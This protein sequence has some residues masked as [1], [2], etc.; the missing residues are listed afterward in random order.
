[1][2]TQ[3]IET[4]TK[5][6]VQ[7][8][9]EENEWIMLNA[10]AGSGKTYFSAQLAVERARQ[11]LLT[12]FVAADKNGMDNFKKLVLN[13]ID[14][15]EQ[16]DLD[17]IQEITAAHG[18]TTIFRPTRIVITHHTYFSFKPMTHHG[19]DVLDECLD[20]PSNLIIIDEAHR[21]FEKMLIRVQIGEYYNCTNKIKRYNAAGTMYQSWNSK[22]YNKVH[23][24]RTDM[25]HLPILEHISNFIENPPESHFEIDITK[26]DKYEVDEIDLKS[27]DWCNYKLLKPPKDTEPDL[28]YPEKIQEL[29][30]KELEEYILN[31]IYNMPYFLEDVRLVEKSFKSRQKIYFKLSE[32]CL[33]LEQQRKIFQE[34]GK[35]ITNIEIQLTDIKGKLYDLEQLHFPSYTLAP[36]IFGLETRAIRKIRESGVTTMVMSATFDSTAR[37]LFDRLSDTEDSIT[38]LQT[39]PKFHETRVNILTHP[40]DIKWTNKLHHYEVEYDSTGYLDTVPSPKLFHIIE[41]LLPMKTLMFTTNKN[42]CEQIID[43]ESKRSNIHHGRNQFQAQTSDLSRREQ[44]DVS[45]IMSSVSF[46]SNRFTNHEVVFCPIRA[47]K[48]VNI[49]F[50][51]TVSQIED[52]I[53]CDAVNVAKQ[54]ISRIIRNDPNAK[55]IEKYIVLYNCEVFSPLDEIT[56]RIGR[57][58]THYISCICKNVNNMGVFHKI[59]NDDEYYQT[60]T[61]MDIV[62][63]ISGKKIFTYNEEVIGSRGR[64]TKNWL[65]HYVSLMK[66]MKAS[67]KSIAAINRKLNF[68]RLKKDSA[69]YDLYMDAL[70]QLF[71]EKELEKF[72]NNNHTFPAE[73]L[74]ITV[75]AKEI[76]IFENETIKDIPTKMENIV[77]NIADDFEFDLDD[78]KIL[79]EEDHNYQPIGVDVDSIDFFSDVGE[80]L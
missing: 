36:E 23:S 47:I 54:N 33:E 64:P 63:T 32:K 3:E 46:G 50:G 18:V 1:M 73:P 20:D 70:K 29:E 76:E 43:L 79:T 31:Y 65:E 48:P 40:S 78:K 37:L 52:N 25:Y 6:F 42:K 77:D 41:T 17:L 62:N 11:D 9:V 55:K 21:W 58:V 39:E 68:S 2:K 5:E 66:P 80:I 22:Y 51:N 45:Y 61:L 15:N 14:Q 16:D 69:K 72:N 38:V 4:L 13:H 24:I 28:I 60:L 67:G 74:T 34:A 49:Y 19:Y 59:I 30:R 27:Y 26:F 75:K 53:V 35:S 57:E 7:K 56:P 12:I 71:T 8:T 10:A 44:L